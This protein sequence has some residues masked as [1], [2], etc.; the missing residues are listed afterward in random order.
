MAQHIKFDT[1]IP[2]LITSLLLS[3]CA[4][5]PHKELS[6]VMRLQQQAQTNYNE[7]DLTQAQSD[8]LELTRV[9]PGDESNWFHLA[10]TYA[11]AGQLEL[12]VNAYRHV[13]AHDATHAKAWHNLGVVLM[14]QSQ[15]AF[16]QS[17]RHAK[18]DPEVQRA[19]LNMGQALEALIHPSSPP[20]S[21]Q[22]AYPPPPVT[23]IE[24][25]P[26]GAVRAP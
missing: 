16:I 8:Y 24:A 22:I 26:P 17:A 9:L 3:A 20:A 11:R 18:A 19:S 21:K 2:I 13:L 15:A 1:I 25:P 6:E 4:T 7:G 12:A 23:D 5:Q 14:Q 10:N